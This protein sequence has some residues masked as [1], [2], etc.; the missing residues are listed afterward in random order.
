MSADLAFKTT[1]LWGAYERMELSV[2]K[3]KY[4]LLATG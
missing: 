1:H 2:I 3:M 4:I